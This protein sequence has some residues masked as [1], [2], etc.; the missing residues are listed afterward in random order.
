MLSEAEAEDELET[1]E[2]EIALVRASLA[3]GAASLAADLERL[4]ARRAELRSILEAYAAERSA[5]AERDRAARLRAHAAAYNA[6]VRRLNA[7]LVEI[8]ANL[9]APGT[10]ARL[11][12][13]R[14]LRPLEE[15]DLS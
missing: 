4:E 7:E 9:P 11:E 15:I 3:G 13:L 8:R 2:G 10:D 14:A 5:Q 1:L 12:P 6:L